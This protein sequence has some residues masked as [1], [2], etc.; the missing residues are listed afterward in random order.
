M[1]QLGWSVLPDD[2]QLMLSREAL[3]RAAATLAKQAELLASEME[4]G[5]VEDQGGP[6]ALRLFAEIVR[7]ANDEGNLQDVPVSGHV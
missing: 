7:E 2:A 1:R 4:D 6:D 3:K 5:L